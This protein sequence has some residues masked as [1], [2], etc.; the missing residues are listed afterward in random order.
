MNLES[1]PPGCAPEGL[2]SL[3][4]NHLE[5]FRPGLAPCSLRV[6]GQD[7]DDLEP[8]SK[9][10]GFPLRRPP[11]RH[12]RGP[13][14]SLWFLG[15]HILKGQNC[16]TV[17]TQHVGRPVTLLKDLIVVFFITSLLLSWFLTVLSCVLHA[18]VKESPKCSKPTPPRCGA[19]TSP[20]MATD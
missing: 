10:E 4:L 2:M 6:S 17:D 8:G 18:A 13:L 19:F 9:G 20:G 15:G 14:F 5:S 1:E 11:G 16:A 12:H 3:T 7:L